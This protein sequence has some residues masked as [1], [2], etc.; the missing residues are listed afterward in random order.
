VKKIIIVVLLFVYFAIY[1]NTN[2]ANGDKCMTDSDC[3]PSAK[4]MKNR[5]GLDG[6]C[7]GG[8]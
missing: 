1:S 2:A 3:D 7:V 6:V 4:C 5:D 8:F